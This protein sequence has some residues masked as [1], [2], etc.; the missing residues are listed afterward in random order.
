MKIQSFERNRI[1]FCTLGVAALVAAC[2]GTSSPG[3][4]NGGSSSGSGS[5]GGIIG[6]SGGKEAGTSSGSGG[7]SSGS[8]SGS[9]GG[10]VCPVEFTDSACQSCFASSCAGSCDACGADR[11]C[12]TA[13]TCLTSCSTSSCESAC[14]SGLSTASAELLSDVLGDP[15]GCIYASCRSDCSTPSSNGDPCITAADCASSYC[16]SDGVHEGWCTIADCTSN[17]QCGVDSAGESVWCTLVSGGGYDCFPGCNSNADCEAYTCASTN[18]SPT[19]G[20]G[21]TITG[22]AE[23]VCGC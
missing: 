17:G 13:L 14:L 12:G 8:G 23:Y 19:C 5:G 20:R 15:N 11:G 18:A 16:D 4:G 1:L 2:S 3:G 10:A 7:T 6:G 9:G 22:S 21:S